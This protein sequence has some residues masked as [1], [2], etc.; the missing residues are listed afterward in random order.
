MFDVDK[1][2]SLSTAEVEKGLCSMGFAAEEMTEVFMQADKNF[3]GQLSL[4]EFQ[5]GVMPILCERMGLSQRLQV[6]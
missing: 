2:G 3:D 1:S 5:E 4:Q 6:C